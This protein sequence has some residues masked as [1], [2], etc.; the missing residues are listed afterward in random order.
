MPSQTIVDMGQNLSGPET[1]SNPEFFNA[2]SAFKPTTNAGLLQ[3]YGQAQQAWNAQMANATITYP[4]F[5]YVPLGPSST[6]PYM[7][8]HWTN[9]GATA[10]S[11][12]PPMGWWERAAR[13]LLGRADS[14]TPVVEEPSRNLLKRVA[15]EVGDGYEM[16]IAGGDNKLAIE[17]ESLLGYRPLRQFLNLAGTL[18][19][20]LAKLDIDILDQASVDAYKMQMV[21]HYSTTGK[22]PYPTWRLTLLERYT[23]QVPKFA[24]RKAVEIKRELPEARFYIDQ[25]AID[26][27]L[28]VSLDDVYDSMANCSRRL[29]PETAAYI[30]V[31]SEPKFEA[32]L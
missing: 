4:G 8:A 27:F 6:N 2:L 14:H 7:Y 21:E 17:A 1:P 13:G 29:D 31:W 5:G 12:Q 18:R 32:T 28:I 20:V 11:S 26:P 10:E 24:L 30:E 23:D 15:V 16:A 25:L 9:G 22:M 19:R 3:T